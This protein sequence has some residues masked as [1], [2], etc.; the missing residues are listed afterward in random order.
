MSQV[1]RSA[2][3]DVHPIELSAEQQALE[4]KRLTWQCRRGMLEMDLLLRAF[5]QQHYAQLSGPQRLAFKDLL[6]LEDDLLWDLML[7]KLEL[8]Q[9]AAFDAVSP[10]HEFVLHALRARSTL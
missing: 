1:A 6:Q 3:D 10:A 9:L 5:L 2:A 4:L 7:G 8:H